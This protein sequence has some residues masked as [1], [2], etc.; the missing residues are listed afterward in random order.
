ML[1]K[2]ETNDLQRRN[3]K[4]RLDLRNIYNQKC[5]GSELTCNRNLQDMHEILQQPYRNLPK[6]S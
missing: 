6:P 5:Y 4:R 1:L 3:C 2:K